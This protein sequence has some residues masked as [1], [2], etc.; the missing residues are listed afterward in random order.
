MVNVAGCGG[1]DN[2]SAKKGAHRRVGPDVGPKS[3]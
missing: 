1:F 2:D 3:N